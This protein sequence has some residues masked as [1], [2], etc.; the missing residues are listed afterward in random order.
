MTIMTPT[1]TFNILIKF[2]VNI[3]CINM[4]VLEITDKNTKVAKM[5]PARKEN[6][7]KFSKFFFYYF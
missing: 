3:F 7:I 1:I 4:P 5:H 2:S 6:Q